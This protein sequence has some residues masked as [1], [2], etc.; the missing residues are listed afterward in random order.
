M[1]ALGLQTIVLFS[2]HCD[3]RNHCDFEGQNCQDNSMKRFLLDQNCCFMNDV[4]PKIEVSTF[5]LI[6]EMSPAHPASR[7]Q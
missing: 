5:L 1:K 7:G 6:V 4:G 2:Q 3:G